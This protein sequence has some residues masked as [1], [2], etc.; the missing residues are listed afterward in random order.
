MS[1]VV[2]LFMPAAL[3]LGKLYRQKWLE[4]TLRFR[5]PGFDYDV[6]HLQQAQGAQWVC[7]TLHT[8]LRWSYYVI[9]GAAMVN[10]V[11]VPPIR[12][13]EG[14]KIPLWIALF[15]LQITAVA[16][17]MADYHKRDDDREMG[18][19]RLLHAADE[20]F[21]SRHGLR[22]R[23]EL[24]GLRSTEY[25]IHGL[26]LRQRRVIFRGTPITCLV[27]RVRGLK[28]LRKRQGPEA[29]NHV[30]VKA[31]AVLKNNARRGSIICRYESASFAVAL[32][33]C[34]RK[35]GLAVGENLAANIQFEV[36][37][38]VQKQHG[39]ELEISW[40]S[41]VMPG[42]A[43]TPVQLLR[44]ADW[45]LKQQVSAL[46]RSESDSV[47]IDPEAGNGKLPPAA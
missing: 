45:K 2:F 30:Q 8:L 11:F 16:I 18:L 26:E 37:D 39:V 6:G 25:W 15:A 4:R 32:F 31:A 47:P 5:T 23:D 13:A 43:S 36:L 7:E 1:V 21:S 14:P 34:P 17:L 22:V 29:A 42:D 28:E 12:G 3:A 41:A 46:R 20:S 40:A 38:W 44:T 33:R 9:S 27:F 10:I 35:R 24:T 19:R